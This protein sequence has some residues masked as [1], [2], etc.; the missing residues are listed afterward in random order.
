ML[1]LSGHALGVRLRVVDPATDAPAREVADHVCADWSDPA[2]PARLADCDAVTYEFER[3]PVALAEAVARRVPVWPPVE[4]LAVAQDRVHEKERFRALGLATPRFRAVDTLADLQRAVAELGLPAVLKTRREGYDGKGQRR[5]RELGEL[6]AAFEA[7][8]PAPLV[9]EEH[10][11][12]DREVSVLAARGRDGAVELYP[13][14]ENRHEHGIL[15]E[16]RVPAPHASGALTE[17]AHRAVRALLDS[18]GYV[19]VLALELFQVGEE[20]LASELAPRVH[21]SGHATIEGAVA[22]Q[23]ENHLRAVVGWPLGPAVATGPVVMLNA[24]GALPDARELLAI[25]GAH[26]HDYGKEPRPG[27]KV[28]HVTITAPDAGELE[29]RAVRARSLVPVVHAGE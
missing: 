25:P 10:V 13:L 3:V 11:A 14:V 2:I 4:A 17:R 28:G 8:A 12:F 24:I 15:I 9:L 1:A 18:F 16:S 29:A 19:G 22:S 26:L 7:L 6:P 23:F 20:L 27:R 21:N 5:L